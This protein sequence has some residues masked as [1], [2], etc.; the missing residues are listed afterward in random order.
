MDVE[1]LVIPEC[2]GADEAS[3]L[4]RTALDD[5]GLAETPVTVRIIDTD[6]LA[7]AP[8]F[9]GLQSIVADGV[10]LFDGGTTRGSMACRMNP[11]PH[12]PRNVPAIRDLRKALKQHAARAA[13]A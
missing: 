5:I 7:R 10:D 12:G 13:R 4:L 6:D 1:L 2:P 3:Q 8:R 9:G 11:A